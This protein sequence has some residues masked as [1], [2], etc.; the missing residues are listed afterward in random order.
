[1][2]VNLHFIDS[3]RDGTGSE[4]N[5]VGLEERRTSLTAR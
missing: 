2:K 1:M 4:P 3:R 5:A